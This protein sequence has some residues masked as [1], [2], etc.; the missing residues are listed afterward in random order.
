MC[1]FIDIILYFCRNV[2]ADC[3]QVQLT[4]HEI[5]SVVFFCA[6]VYWTIY[7]GMA[8]NTSKILLYSSVCSYTMT[9]VA[10]MMQVQSSDDVTLET[11]EENS[12][13]LIVETCT[14]VK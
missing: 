4:L 1:A 8:Q 6:L 10:C 13:P 12:E 5:H 11:S 3:M 9:F 14:V 2:N 7:G